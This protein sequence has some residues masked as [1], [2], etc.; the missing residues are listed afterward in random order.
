MLTGIPIPKLQEDILETTKN[1][2][3]TRNCI[4]I[5]KDARTVVSDGTECYVNVSGNNGMATGGSGDVLTG[6]IG[7]LLAQNVNPFSAAK[8]GVYLHG[9]SGDVAAKQKSPYGVMASDLLDG[10]TEVLTNTKCFQKEG[11]ENE[12]V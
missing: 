8:L 1:T 12:T 6:V 7:G 10:L 11:N 2:A 4:L 9:L 5:Q 3:K